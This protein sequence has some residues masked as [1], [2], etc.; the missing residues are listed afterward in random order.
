MVIQKASQDQALSRVATEHNF[1]LLLI[2]DKPETG[3]Q[4][5]MPRNWHL[6]LV[7]NAGN[8]NSGAERGKV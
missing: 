5:G 1:T 6:K 4:H 2:A 3:A 8:P 7:L